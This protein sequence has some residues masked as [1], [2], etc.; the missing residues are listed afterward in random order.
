MDFYDKFFKLRLEGSNFVKGPFLALPRGFK[1]AR[2]SFHVILGGREGK[3]AREKVISCVPILDLTDFPGPPECVHVL[4]ED[5]FHEFTA[6][7]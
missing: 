4:G 6:S 1:S 3:P 2:E 7:L 5:Y